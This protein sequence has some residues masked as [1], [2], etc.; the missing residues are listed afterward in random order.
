MGECELP[1]SVDYGLPC[2]YLIA[3]AEASS[4]L[5]RYD[6][7]RYGPRADADSYREMVER[8]RDAG[9]GDEPK[10]RIMLGT[11]ALSAGYYDAYYGQAQKVRTLIMRRAPRRV[12][13]VRRARRRRPRR[14]SRSRSASVRPIR[15]RCT[16]PIC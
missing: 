15:S 7:V 13:A 6:G 14:R 8:T 4:N 12:R 2:Y 10:R 16:P 3:P 11:Y 5:A 9:F 1:L